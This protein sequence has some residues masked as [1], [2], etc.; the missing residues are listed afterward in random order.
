[1][2]CYRVDFCRRVNR[3]FAGQIDW[4]DREELHVIAETAR[5]AIDMVEKIYVGT[6]DDDGECVAVDVF[7]VECALDV[8]A[9]PGR[10]LRETRFDIATSGSD[11]LDEPG[12]EL[13]LRK[14][15][16]AGL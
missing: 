6:A 1:M 4:L 8:A 13:A 7:E 16:E 3:L 14:V 12:G 9:W 2:Q 11:P 15:R 5:E 10:D